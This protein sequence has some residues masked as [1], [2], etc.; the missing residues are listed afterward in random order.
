M[1]TLIVSASI[2][3]TLLFASNALALTYVGSYGTELSYELRGATTGSSFSGTY[4][5]T[6]TKPGNEQNIY[7]D[8]EVLSDFI[9]LINYRFTELSIDYSIASF[10]E[11]N[12]INGS[13]A[14]GSQT[15]TLMT[16]TYD[17]DSKTGTW[18]TA[19]VSVEFYTVKGANEFA[20]YWLGED[21]AGS[22]AWSTEHLISGKSGAPEISHFTTINATDVP[23]VPEP[24]TFILLGGG[25]VGLAFYR[26]RQK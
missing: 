3:A 10:D 7:N 6:M 18:S 5:L 14:D 25:L 16:V 1:K 26:R 8:L 19:P 15:S 22:G 11:Y 23:P 17:S 9:E 4:L 20:L 24:A 13:I 2:L 12:K 21:G